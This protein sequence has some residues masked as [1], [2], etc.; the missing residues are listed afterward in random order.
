MHYARI[1]INKNE[2]FV[3]IIYTLC[4]CF[5]QEISKARVYM[6]LG[7]TKIIFSLCL[8]VFTFS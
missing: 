3:F 5:S 6:H 1:S 8:S 2:V 7:K 4:V